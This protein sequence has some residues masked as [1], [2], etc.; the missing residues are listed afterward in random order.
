MTVMGRIVIVLMVMLIRTSFVAI[1]RCLRFWA[2]RRQ[3]RKFVH[4]SAA[5]FQQQNLDEV[6]AVAARNRKSHIAAIAASALASAEGM[7]CHLRHEETIDAAK[8][9]MERS[10]AMSYAEMQR[11]LGSPATVASVVVVMLASYIPA[12]RATRID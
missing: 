4:Q 10:S 3:S 5:A 2:A 9:S 12:R 1:S 7:P 11:G 8:R 6:I